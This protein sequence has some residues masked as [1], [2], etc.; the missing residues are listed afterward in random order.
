MS[1][2]GYNAAT[3]DTPGH[4]FDVR[5]DAR[6]AGALP[7]ISLDLADQ[8][9]TDVA[10]DDA[11]GDLYAA[12]DY[13]VLRLPDGRDAGASRRRTAAPRSPLPG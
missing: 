11:T 13:G 2:S 7:D 10:Y 8:P 4:V 5:F 1:Y 6:K 3:P 12:T 9:I